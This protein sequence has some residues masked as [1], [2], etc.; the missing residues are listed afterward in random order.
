MKKVKAVEVF[1]NDRYFQLV[2]KRHGEC[3]MDLFDFI[4]KR[5]TEEMPEDLA[6]H[7]FT[8]VCPT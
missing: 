2:M 1:S 8:Q 4:E 5:R 3:I 6:H 7:I